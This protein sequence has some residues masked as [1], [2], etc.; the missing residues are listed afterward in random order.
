[1]LFLNSGKSWQNVATFVL[2]KSSGRREVWEFEQFT[3]RDRAAADLTK[4][5]FDPSW[6]AKWVITF[7]ED[8]DHSSSSSS[9]QRGSLHLNH[10]TVPIA[11]FIK[12]YAL[13]EGLDWANVGKID[14]FEKKKTKSR[15]S[16]GIITPIRRRSEPNTQ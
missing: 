10:V 16:S 3:S 13:T 6:L 11:Q 14:G 8:T 15:P 2:A 5:L 4:E 1:M 12:L 9:A 7:K